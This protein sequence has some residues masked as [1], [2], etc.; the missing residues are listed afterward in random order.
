MEV[1]HLKENVIVCGPLF[2][3]PVQVSATVP[4]GDSV[5][6]VGKGLDSGQVYRPVLTSAQVGTLVANPE[7][8]PFDSAPRRFRLSIEALRLAL[9]Y[10][11]DPYFSLSTARVDPPPHQLEA[12][13][14]SYT[15]EK[16]WVDGLLARGKGLGF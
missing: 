3:E 9:A 2:P 1:E 11:Y 7:Q 6:L 4:M 16:R 5:K 15:Q 12:V 8:E 14:P 10:A 13:Y